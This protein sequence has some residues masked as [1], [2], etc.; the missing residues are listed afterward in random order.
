MT[1][2]EC[3]A[4]MGTSKHCQRCGAPVVELAQRQSAAAKPTASVAAV[5]LRDVLAVGAYMVLGVANFFAVGL[6]LLWPAMY[7]TQGTP[8]EA[9]ADYL[10]RGQML[11]ATIIFASLPTLTAYF[12]IRRLRRRARQRRSPA[13]D[14]Q[15][16]P[17]ESLD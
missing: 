15:V 4:D 7:A 11:I 10:P 13:S 2:V 8:A 17:P 12:L 3:G 9:G 6:A 14:W 5:T 1:C 16:L